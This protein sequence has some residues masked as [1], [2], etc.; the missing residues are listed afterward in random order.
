MLT[1]KV[2]FSGP[3]PRQPQE[4][5]LIAGVSVTEDFNVSAEGG[6][7]ISNVTDLVLR[8]SC[9]I[10]SSGSPEWATCADLLC[11]RLPD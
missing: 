4:D 10:I 5:A 3:V 7:T 2:A 9:C 1:G 8:Q 11:N 6:L